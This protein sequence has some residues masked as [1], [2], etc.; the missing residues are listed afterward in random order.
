MLF[1]EVIGQEAVK[2]QLLKSV[3]ERRV[4]HALLLA[5][6]P[7][8][9]NFQLALAFA[10][11]LQC[12]N[13]S[14]D[15]SCGVC[16]PCVQSSKYIHPDIHFSFPMAKTP[17]MRESIKG[18]DEPHSDIYLPVWREFMTQNPFPS[19]DA[20]HE[21]MGV[22]NQQSMIYKREAAEIL[23]KL[24]FKSFESD[25]KVLIMWLPEKM[26]VTTANKLLKIIEEPPLQT[27]FLF[28]TSQPGDLLPTILSR[29]QI[30][31]VPMLGESALRE[32][33]L[34]E[35]PEAG[36]AL[37]D[38]L[39]LAQGDYLEARSRLLRNDQIREYRELFIRWTRLSYGMK[40]LEIQELMTEFSEMGRERQK[41]FFDY[42]LGL[43]RQNL[44]LNLGLSQVALLDQEEAG[45]SEKFNA[46]IHRGNI[47]EIS[48]ELQN[49]ANQIGM[50]ANPKILFTDLSFRLSRLLSMPR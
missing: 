46:F 34:T 10:Q 27:V 37:D 3:H 7:G 21:A 44:M 42:A 32:R 22:E 31:K 38:V 43:V 26:N 5:G 23:R 18:V 8:T 25:F 4:S 33:L 47:A 14:A 15:D 20:W 13:P 40:Y 2:R 9:G 49:A 35:Y 48:R 41:A 28:V 19:I 17:L 16:A 50:N 11:Y 1:R 45:F 36:D 24:S 29:T 6:S 30:I 12:R 39:R